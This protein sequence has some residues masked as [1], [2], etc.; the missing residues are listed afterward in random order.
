MKKTAII[1]I[2]ILALASCNSD[3]SKNNEQKTENK[4]V[5]KNIKNDKNIEKKQASKKENILDKKNWN[6]TYIGFVSTTCPHCIKE[7][8]ILEKFYGTN[9][10]KVN[11]LMVVVNNKNFDGYTIPQK[12]QSEIEEMSYQ[13]ITWEECKFVPSFV[14]YDENKK[15]IEKKCWWALNIEGLKKALLKKE[16]VLTWTTDKAV[17]KEQEKKN[18]LDIKLN[19]NMV[20]KKWS[21][22]KVH[23]I[24]KT[25]DDGKEFDNSY[26]RGDTLPFTVGAGQ[27]IKGFDAGVVD[28]KVW[29][30]KTIEIAPKDGYGESNPNAIQIIPR[31]Q[32]ADFEKHGIKLEVGS[33]LPTNRWK[34]KIIKVDDKNITVD[35]NHDLAWKTL[36]F[37]VEMVEVK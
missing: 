5:E 20:A 37:E 19:K 2:S 28:M 24:G 25:K 36:I 27:M 14:I 11:M 18:N 32:L 17:E 30:K 16:K 8:P 35:F 15:I 3:I 31:E 23:Y 4:K 26:K 7:M 34:W 13:K 12:K 22:V 29:D 9:K 10:W 33:E 21:K 1:L 6:K